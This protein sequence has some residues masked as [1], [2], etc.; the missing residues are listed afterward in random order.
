MLVYL[1]CQPCLF[2]PSLQALPPLRA[3]SA[4]VGPSLPSF[5]LCSARTCLQANRLHIHA[6]N[7]PEHSRSPLQACL[8][9]PS[10]LCGCH[11]AGRTS[12]PVCQEGLQTFAAEAKSTGLRINKRDSEEQPEKET[13]RS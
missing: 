13:Y 2:P 11:D 10:C 5:A 12:T 4:W 3:A 9:F 6:Q 7:I 8:I 1:R